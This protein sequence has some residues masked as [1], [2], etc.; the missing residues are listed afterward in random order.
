MTKEIQLFKSVWVPSE[1]KFSFKEEVNPQTGERKYILRGM[2]LPF[3]KISRNNVMYNKESIVQ[4]H[5]ELVGRPVM[6]NHKIDDGSLPRGHFTESTI[7]EDGWYYGADI[8]PQ[9]KELIRKLERGD[10]RH[11]SI[12]L[13]GGKV[14]E[15]LNTEGNTY[16][17]AYVSDVIEGSI[18]PAPGFLD[19]TA[20]F[21]EAFKTKEKV[22][23]SK[24][25]TFTFINGTAV[26]KPI[27]IS[28][29]SI[30]TGTWTGTTTGTITG[31]KREDVTTTTAG[32]AIAPAKIIGR[33]KEN[34]QEWEQEDFDILNQLKTMYPEVSEDVLA[35]LIMD[36]GNMFVDEIEEP[37]EVV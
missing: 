33:R 27:T 22:G 21:S 10:L 12:Q 6:Y 37:D 29:A 30:T 36:I 11:V 24:N 32:G 1:A 25:G 17:E 26:N 2:M 9:E 14:I 8:D 35:S 28:N 31:I 15:R 13:I 5:K 34:D 20:S 7:K 23:L 4:K 16:T 3:G 18:V 19:T